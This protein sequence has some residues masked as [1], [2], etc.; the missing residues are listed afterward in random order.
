MA[1]NTSLLSDT[2]QHLQDLIRFKDQKKDDLANLGEE[3]EEFNKLKDEEIIHLKQCQ[4]MFS[5][6]L[7]VKK[8]SLVKEMDIT[9]G[10]IE[11]LVEVLK[12]FE[13]SN[14]ENVLK[15]MKDSTGH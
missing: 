7:D 10:K 1:S 8:Q 9:D 5:S 13:V 6:K 14:L 3:Q 15:S 12:T 11:D 4:Q 2:V